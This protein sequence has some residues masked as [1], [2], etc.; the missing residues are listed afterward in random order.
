MQ[1]ERDHMRQF[2]FDAW[3]KHQ[4]QLSLN[5]LEQLT[6]NVILMHPEYHEILKNREEALRQDYRTDDNPFLH[7]SLHLGLIEQIQN[8]RPQ[9]IKTIYQHLCKKYPDHH[10]VE[11]L[12][13]EV[14]ANVLWDAQQ[15]NTLPDERVYLE[16][17]RT[18]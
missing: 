5:A 13:M 16:N 15:N 4:N 1:N 7:M 10:Q 17:L 9:G 8:D 3:Q 14:M 18:L 11:H 12:M 6:I 2:F